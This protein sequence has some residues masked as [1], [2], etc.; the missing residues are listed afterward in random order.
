MTR[1]FTAM[2]R[3][4]YVEQF[5]QSGL[6][7]TAFCNQR[8]LKCKTF[9]KWI[10]SAS[11]DSSPNDF[12]TPPFTSQEQGHFVPIHLVGDVPCDSSETN[13]S[14]VLS[15]KGKGFCLE[16]PL[17]VSPDTNLGRVQSVIHIL[18]SLP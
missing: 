12:M 17:E 13:R 11:R 2:E 8:N 5:K 15:L 10:H 1:H 6:T 4:T 9:N 18:H 7:Q 3:Q 14:A 16:L